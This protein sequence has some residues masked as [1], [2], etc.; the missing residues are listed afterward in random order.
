MLAE[1]LILIPHHGYN[2]KLDRKRS[3]KKLSF[4]PKVAT[5]ST[6][7]EKIGPKKA[8]QNAGQNTPGLQN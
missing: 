2:Q 8:A 7:A 6:P 3:A 4:M 5:I 1:F